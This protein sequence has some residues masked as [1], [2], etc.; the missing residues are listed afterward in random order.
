MESV[1][2]AE[3]SAGAATY[4]YSKMAEGLGA[5]I[6]N[7]TTSWQGFTA[8]LVDTE[9][10]ISVLKGVTNFLNSLSEVSGL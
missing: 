10:V 5:T 3:K 9:F 4:Q 1:T 8:S 6:T 7:L 2:I